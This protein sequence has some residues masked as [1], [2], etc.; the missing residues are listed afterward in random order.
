[1]K[2]K[3]KA[4]FALLKETEILLGKKTA[5][6]HMEKKDGLGGDHGIQGKG[7]RGISISGGGGLLP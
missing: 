2:K 5:G 6:S 4:A 7:R 1:M 3:E